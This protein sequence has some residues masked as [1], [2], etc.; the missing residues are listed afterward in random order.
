MNCYQADSCLEV[1]HMLRRC[2]RN[3]MCHLFETFEW[4]RVLAA[5]ILN[6]RADVLGSTFHHHAVEMTM[7]SSEPTILQILASMICLHSRIMLVQYQSDGTGKCVDMLWSFAHDQNATVSTGI[8]SMCGSLLARPDELKKIATNGGQV[9][10]VPSHCSYNDFYLSLFFFFFL[11]FFLS[12][13]C[14]AF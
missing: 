14:K 10:W 11:F 5:G 6:V 2:I 8:R 7:A 13:V 12:S 3:K 4:F 1:T 9:Y